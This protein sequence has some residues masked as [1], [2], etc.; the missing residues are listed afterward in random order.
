MSH[1]SAEESRVNCNNNDDPCPDGDP[2]LSFT[3]NSEIDYETDLPCMEIQDLI[4]SGE[5]R[6]DPNHV[7]VIDHDV[8]PSTST[9]KQTLK[10]KRPEGNLPLILIIIKFH[11][12]DSKKGRRL[13]FMVMVVRE[14]V[15]LWI[16]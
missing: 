1:G 11:F 14:S 2:E 7:E 12:H 4:S 10:N 6:I 16:S 9:N 5:G 3:T 15:I 8:Q 13:P